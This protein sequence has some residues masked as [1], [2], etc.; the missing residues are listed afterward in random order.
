[1]QSSQSG[2]KTYRRIL[3]YVKP[4][5]FLMLLALVGNAL[6]SAM[7]GYVIHLLKPLMDKGFI[8]K[9]L[10][11]LETFPL[12]LIGI[13]AVRGTANVMAT[14]CFGYVSGYVVSDIRR[15]LFAKFMRLPA[16]AYDKATS[17][18]MISKL[19]YNVDQISAAG[20]A[21]LTTMVRE[22]ALIISLLV[23]MFYT[24]W[25]LSLVLLIIVPIIALLISF[26]SKHFRRL[27]HKQQH[28]MAEVTH[29]TEESLKSYREI[30]IFGGQAYQE[31]SFNKAIMYALRYNLKFTMISA[32]NSPIV[33]MVGAVA[34]SLVI[35]IAVA[36]L[37]VSAG[38]FV[39]MIT[40]MVAILKPLRNITGL[41]AGLQSGVAAAQSVFAT[42][43]AEEEKDTGTTVLARTRGHVQFKNVSFSYPG[44]HKTVLHEINIDVKPGESIA[45]VGRSGSGK[46]TFV[47][48]LP[49]FYDATSGD[50]ILDGISTHDITLASLREQIAVV[51]QHVAL[52]NDTIFH[53]I[54]YSMLGEV[55]EEKVIEAAKMAHAWEFIEKLPNGLY[56]VTGENGV[57]LSGGQRQRLAIAR[58]LLKK[59]PILILDEATSALDNESERLIQAAIETI[60]KQSTTFVIAHRLSTIEH[61]DRILV[62]DEGRIIESGSHQELM[63]AEGAYADLRAFAMDSNH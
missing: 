42:V 38:T 5:W 24:S 2:L 62:M 15:Q 6:Y 48:L 58:A 26:A 61:V 39:T 60:M 28:A 3:S 53:N 37:H 50:I 25:R 46:S 57:M 31:Q 23:V 11:Y 4:Y 56:T 44:H 59:A 52:F 14:Y 35:Y 10:A 20:G 49:R 55:D 16:S 13:F 34:M 1:M 21:S 36:K 12:V 19:L 9:D 47:S 22:V 51:S 41:N 33:Q 63:S 18:Q 45:L 43:D 7:D 27:S 30:R 17:G 54:A 8:D 29:V 32:L 40:A